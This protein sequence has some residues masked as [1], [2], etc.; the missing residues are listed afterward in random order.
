MP[1]FWPCTTSFVDVSLVDRCSCMSVFLVPRLV[2][3]LNVTR[4]SF[5]GASVDCVLSFCKGCDAFVCWPTLFDII[6]VVFFV[7]VVSLLAFLTTDSRRELIFVPWL[8]SPILDR[9]RVA[10]V[11]SSLYTLCAIS[12]APLPHNFEP[13][14]AVFRGHEGPSLVHLS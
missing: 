13:A 7:L 3:S 2:G 14:G 9:S 6:A 11:V 1:G 4:G 10:L 5:G 8:F 12:R